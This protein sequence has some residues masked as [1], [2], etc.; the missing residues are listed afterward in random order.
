MYCSLLYNIKLK[1]N[2]CVE[3]IT[4]CVGA[5]QSIFCAE[6]ELDFFHLGGSSYIVNLHTLKPERKNQKRIV[7]KEIINRS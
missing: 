3:C 2:R 7:G 6:L 1:L 4:T 5:P